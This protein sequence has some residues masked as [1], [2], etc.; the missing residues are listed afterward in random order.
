MSAAE[1]LLGL[2]LANDWKVTRQLGQ[3]PNQRAAPS[4]RAT[5]SRSPA[6]SVF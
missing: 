3:E 2:T 5:W 6:G 4:P 1:K